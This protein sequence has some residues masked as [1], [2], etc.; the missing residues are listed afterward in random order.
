MTYVFVAAPYGRGRPNKQQKRLQSRPR[1][2]RERRVRDKRKNCCV[3]VK[4]YKTHETY[5]ALAAT[6]YCMPAIS[7]SVQTRKVECHVR[8][9]NLMSR[10]SDANVQRYAYNVTL[11]DICDL[12]TRGGHEAQ[13]VRSSFSL[14][15]PDASMRAIALEVSSS[16]CFSLRLISS[17]LESFRARFI[18]ACRTPRTAVLAASAS[19]LACLASA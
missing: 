2:A 16:I 6:W 17:L 8:R 9:R 5:L 7:G 15:F 18:A 13:T 1:A 19:T 3:T 4:R 11:T 14:S 10:C 12:P